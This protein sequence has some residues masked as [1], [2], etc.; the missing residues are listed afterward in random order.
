MQ[1]RQGLHKALPAQSQ[2]TL[3]LLLQWPIR[4]RGNQQTK[5]ST[6]GSTPH[7][8]PAHQTIMA[9]YSRAPAQALRPKA[10]ESAT[11]LRHTNPKPLLTN[12]NR[13]ILFEDRRAV[14]RSRRCTMLHVVRCETSRD[15]NG[16]LGAPPR[17]A[18]AVI[19]GYL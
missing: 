3:P 14:G 16:L 8:K 9:A 4:L 2:S 15:F 10:L 19:A 18:G 17:F 11:S 1:L 6:A 13:T 12:N 7:R 5:P